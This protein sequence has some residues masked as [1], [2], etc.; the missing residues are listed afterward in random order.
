MR[1]TERL[2]CRLC[3]FLSFFFVAKRGFSF[4]RLTKTSHRN[5]KHSTSEELD[6]TLSSLLRFTRAPFGGVHWV[7]AV[8][9]HT[10]SLL[11]SLGTIPLS[12]EK[13]RL[14]QRYSVLFFPWCLH[15]RTSDTVEHKGVCLR[16]HPFGPDDMGAFF[17]I[18]IWSALGEQNQ[19][20]WP[21]LG[22]KQQEMERKEKDIVCFPGKLPPL[23]L[24]FPR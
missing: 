19:K 4:N 12:P 14:P 11:T 3:F 8:V 2:T 23:F 5:A 18:L 1:H 16:K 10:S 13:N 15:D 7:V 6:R 9:C 20:A 17:V 24:L 21:S 22:C